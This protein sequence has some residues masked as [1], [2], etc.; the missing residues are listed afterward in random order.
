MRTSS[1]SS[2]VTAINSGMN[3]GGLVVDR[4]TTTSLYNITSN[5][6]NNHNNGGL[7]SIS[8]DPIVAGTAKQSTSIYPTC[9]GTLPLPGPVPMIITGTNTPNQTGP[10]ECCACGARIIALNQANNNSSSNSDS[11]ISSNEN[12]SISPNNQSDTSSLEYNGKMS[13]VKREVANNDNNNK[14]SIS[15]TSKLAQARLSGN[16]NGATSSPSSSSMS[17]DSNSPPSSS[18]SSSSAWYKKAWLVRSFSRSPA[19][20]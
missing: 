20:R 5:V 2:S 10:L 17:S 8:S 16:S 4:G 15:M 7:K 11:S 1:S 12:I 3:M 19:L 13:S 14:N 6:D 9:T 18:S